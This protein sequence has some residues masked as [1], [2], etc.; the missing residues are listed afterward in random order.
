MRLGV[1]EMKQGYEIGI[2]E[3]CTHAHMPSDCTRGAG[4]E[5][6]R[7]GMAAGAILLE[8]A[9]ATVGCCRVAGAG[10]L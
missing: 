2:A 9:L 5:V 3:V 4:P 8:D 1:Q 10:K 6:F 7:R